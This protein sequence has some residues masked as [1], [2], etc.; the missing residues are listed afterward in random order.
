MCFNSMHVC[1]SPNVIL[2]ER[3]TEVNRLHFCIDMIQ[4]LLH[5]PSS[6]QQS[7]RKILSTLNE[8]YIDSQHLGYRW[9]EYML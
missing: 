4:R 3:I 7:Y 5:V 6:S 1:A 2:R 9:L 8:L